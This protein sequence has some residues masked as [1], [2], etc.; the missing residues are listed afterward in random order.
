MRAFK[1]LTNHFNIQ[2]KKD[3]ALAITYLFN[4][5]VVLNLDKDYIFF[6]FKDKNHNI[7]NLIYYYILCAIHNFKNIFR[8]KSSFRWY[9]AGNCCEFN[10][11]LLF[12]YN[13]LG[14][15]IIKKEYQKFTFTKTTYL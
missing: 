13:K 1:F 6:K 4:K 8:I 5:K 11:K 14:G 12:L 2:F 15:T 7:L 3:N 9:F 10:Q